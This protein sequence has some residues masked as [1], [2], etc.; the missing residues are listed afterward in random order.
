MIV[1]NRIEYHKLASGNMAMKML[2]CID[3]EANKQDNERLAVT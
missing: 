3:R 1:K 2:Q